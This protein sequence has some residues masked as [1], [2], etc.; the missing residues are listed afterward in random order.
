MRILSSLKSFPC[1]HTEYKCHD[2]V[3]II[4]FWIY[5]KQLAVNMNSY[6]SVILRCLDLLTLPAY[7][8]KMN[9]SY[10]YRDFR[11]KDSTVWWLCHLYNGNL[12]ISSGNTAS[13]CWI[14]TRNTIYYHTNINKIMYIIQNSKGHVHFPCMSK[15]NCSIIS[16][17]PPF[18][19]GYLWVA[20]SYSFTWV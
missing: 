9:M 7:L 6:H 12:Y 13:L 4:S 16:A 8:L 10:Q 5:K 14:K 18:K 11:F 17:K 19:L 1:C 2:A 15:T 3:K 20:A